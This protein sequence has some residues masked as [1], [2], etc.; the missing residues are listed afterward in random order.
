MSREQ[1][2]ER[3]QNIVIYNSH[4]ESLE[5]FKYLGITWTDQNFIQEVLKADWS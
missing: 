3:S 1:N 2:A 5:E 4:F